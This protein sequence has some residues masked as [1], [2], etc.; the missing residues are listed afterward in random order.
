MFLFVNVLVPFLIGNESCHDT[1]SE[2][3]DREENNKHMSLLFLIYLKD[4]EKVLPK[5]RTLFDAEI[6]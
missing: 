3:E 4:K 2:E 1:Y 6:L 5:E